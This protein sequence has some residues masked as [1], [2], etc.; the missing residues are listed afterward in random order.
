MPVNEEIKDLATRI[1]NEC[2]EKP[3]ETVINA[4]VQTAMNVIDNCYE[5][6]E[7]KIETLSK[8]QDALEKG[9]NYFRH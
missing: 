2:D 3:V 4:L 9:K 7:H 5:D 8:M 6:T 1:M